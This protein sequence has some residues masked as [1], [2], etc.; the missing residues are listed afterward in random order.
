MGRGKIQRCFKLVAREFKK[1]RAQK[2]MQ[3]IF[4]RSHGWYSSGKLHNPRILLR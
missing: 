2:G 1:T 3:S 4:A